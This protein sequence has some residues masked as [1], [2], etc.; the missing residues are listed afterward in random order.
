MKSIAFRNWL[1][2]TQCYQ[3]YVDKKVTQ[4]M[5]STVYINYH[6]HEK[7]LSKQKCSTF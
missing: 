3:D 6:K 2:P 7:T 5:R 1:K 4:L